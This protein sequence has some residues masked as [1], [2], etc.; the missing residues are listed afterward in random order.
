[1]HVSRPHLYLVHEKARGGT[2]IVDK[3]ELSCVCSES[4]PGGP[5]DQPELFI[6]KPSS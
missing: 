5:E 3:L 2:G 1:M 6:A 4:N